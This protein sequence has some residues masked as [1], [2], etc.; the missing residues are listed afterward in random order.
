MSRR[1][2]QRGLSGE[3]V[4]S[5]SDEF[6]QL[7]KVSGLADHDG[8]AGDRP[9]PA[10]PRVFLALPA[11]NP[12]V[13]WEQDDRGLVTLIYRK[14]FGRFERWL[15]AKIGGPEDVKR[16]LDRMGSRM[17]LLMDGEH[18]ILDICRIMDIEFKEEMA[19][20][21]KKVR[22]F[23]EQLLILNLVILNPPEDEPG[24]GTPGDGT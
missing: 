1:I 7:R 21:L 15:H 12:L 23:L 11:P 20:V 16:P 18:T 22:M 17:W 3:T 2:G 24:H 4:G 9:K 14:N 5:R 19:P 8:A 13:I 10:V 6:E